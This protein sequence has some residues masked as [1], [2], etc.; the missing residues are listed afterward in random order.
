MSERLLI[1]DML[2]YL[3]EVQSFTQSGIDAFIADTKTQYATIY[4]Y[5]V[6]GEIAKRLPET[7]RV[8]H[9][10]ID[11]R[12]LIGFRDFLAHNYDKILVGS[13][14]TAIT[15]V[16]HLMSTLQALHD[17]LGEE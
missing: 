7:F 9:P 2:R 11:W 14:W 8:A 15:D 13:M 12:K 6:I 16:A 17:S 3:N 4:A 10:D 1:R 5:Q